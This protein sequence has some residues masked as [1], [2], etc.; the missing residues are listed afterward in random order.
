MCVQSSRLRKL[1]KQVSAELKHAMV[2]DSHMWLFKVN[3]DRHDHVDDLEKWKREKQDHD[4]IEQARMAMLTGPAKERRQAEE[5]RKAPSMPN[6]KL[7]L[8]K[9]ELKALHQQIEALER[10]A[11]RDDA[12]RAKAALL[13]DDGDAA[14]N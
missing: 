3:V 13:A 1:L 10:S 7:T 9:P 8:T 6:L 11:Q 2:D 14:A 4:M 5:F 12:R